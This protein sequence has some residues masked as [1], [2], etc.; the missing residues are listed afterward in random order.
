M[1]VLTR[2][3][4]DHDTLLTMYGAMV[5]TRMCETA[6]VR[7]LAGQDDGYRP[8]RGLEAVAAGTV[9]ALAPG[10]RLVTTPRCLHELI[11][12]G[13]PLRDV[14]GMLLAPGN[15]A[16]VDPLARAHGIVF[17]ATTPGAGIPVAAG[18]ALAAQGTGSG[19]VVVVSF[20]ADT[21]DTGLF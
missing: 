14:V 4:S 1:A 17:S 13:V 8:V 7:R 16:L 18:A 2:P 21:A 5:K 19:R 20:G 6:V 10:D 11:A 12:C 9:D 3:G 15:T